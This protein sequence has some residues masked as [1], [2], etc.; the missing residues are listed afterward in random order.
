MEWHF[1][2]QIDNHTKPFF[3]LMSQFYFVPVVTV[4][5][6][7]LKLLRTLSL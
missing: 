5:F 3:P 4:K 2:K 6:F 7:T 1:K